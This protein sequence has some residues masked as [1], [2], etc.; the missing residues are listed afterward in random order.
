MLMREIKFRGKSTVF[1]KGW[2]Y[3]YLTVAVGGK[4]NW[5]KITNPN[6]PNCYDPE[7]DPETVGEFTGFKDVDGKEIYE[8]D[9]LE[10]QG[11]LKTRG[12]V[13]DIRNFVYRNIA[14]QFKV[15]G[16]IHDNPELLEVEK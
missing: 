11:E 1:G 13:T 15:I 14:Y 12:V 5:F 9:I 2:R 6:A 8:G 10:Y 16:N 7:V 4:G 3:G